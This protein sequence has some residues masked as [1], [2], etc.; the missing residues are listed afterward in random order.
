[1]KTQIPSQRH[2]RR[3]AATEKI[4]YKIEGSIPYIV[5]I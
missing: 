4:D 3:V 2:H 1:M 5:A